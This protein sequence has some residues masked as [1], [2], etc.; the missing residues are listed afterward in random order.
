[1]HEAQAGGL[2]DKRGHRARGEAGRGAAGGLAVPRRW[3]WWGWFGLDGRPGRSWLPPPE[4]RRR[5]VGGGRWRLRCPLV[6][7]TAALQAARPR[8]ASLNPARLFQYVLGVV[9]VC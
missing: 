8:D 6:R 1:M 3:W 7:F 5:R 4:T 2:A 9:G